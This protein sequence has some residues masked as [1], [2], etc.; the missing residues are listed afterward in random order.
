MH[1]RMQSDCWGLVLHILFTL[2]LLYPLIRGRGNVYEQNDIRYNLNSIIHRNFETT[3]GSGSA[4]TI[5]NSTTLQTSTHIM[6]FLQGPVLDA[7]FQCG[8]ETQGGTCD[9]N[10]T[11][12]YTQYTILGN[13]ELH[14]YR[15][16]STLG[17]NGVDAVGCDG[18]MGM[19][20]CS[21][22]LCSSFLCS[23]FLCS[24]F[25]TYRS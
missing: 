23:S 8:Q 21:S 3:S 5:V 18:V 15:T 19:L 6:D 22:F 12:T 11:S 1:A 24:S 2:A 16:A 14:Q 25:S 17:R 20:L 13:L 7:I 10:S 9:T 4:A